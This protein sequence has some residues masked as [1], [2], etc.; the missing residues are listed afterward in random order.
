MAIGHLPGL[1]VILSIIFLG[2]SIVI[3]ALDGEVEIWKSLTLPLIYHAL[4]DVSLRDGFSESFTGTECGACATAVTLV[5][6][7][8]AG[9]SVLRRKNLRQWCDR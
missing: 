8:L 1:V 5:R 4:E 7:H 3:T 9:T 6:Q 2:L